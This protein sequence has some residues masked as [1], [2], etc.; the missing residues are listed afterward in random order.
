LAKNARYLPARN[1]I[2]WDLWGDLRKSTYGGQAVVLRCTLINRTGQASFESAPL[3][4]L[5]VRIAKSQQRGGSMDVTVQGSRDI[6]SYAF[7]YSFAERGEFHPL[8]PSARKGDTFTF[9]LASLGRTYSNFLRLRV[10]GF[11]SDRREAEDTGTLRLVA[12]FQPAAASWSG[13][14]LWVSYT[15]SWKVSEEDV[16]F[17]CFARKDGRTIGATTPMKRVF[18]VNHRAVAWDVYADLTRLGVFELSDVG[19]RIDIRDPDQGSFSSVVSFDRLPLPPLRLEGTKVNLSGSSLSFS[20]QRMTRASSQPAYSVRDY[21]I[22]AEYFCP[23][24]QR[25]RSAQPAS[26]GE[27]PRRFIWKRRQSMDAVKAG[28]W[29]RLIVTRRN[30]PGTVGL[31]LFHVTLKPDHSFFDDDEEY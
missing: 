24:T 12:G 14:Y 7:F 26:G 27:K 19:F 22:E 6:T 8:K 11:T 21:K 25:F 13:K 15:V 28:T 23:H 30:Q 3:H 2:Q 29:V 31:A 10:V 20:F 18:D 9:D 5:Y 4:P 17:A 1:E 16:R